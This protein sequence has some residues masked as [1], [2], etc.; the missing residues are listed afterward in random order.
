MSNIRFRHF[1]NADGRMI[2][3]IATQDLPDGNIAVGLSRVHDRDQP[4]RSK[5]RL[6]TSQRL[7]AFA[8]GRMSEHA[9]SRCH[10]FS[11]TRE[12]LVN[13]IHRNPFTDLPNYYTI[14]ELREACR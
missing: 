1:R 13:M 3:T 14:D 11:M 12:E 4:S 8:N 9:K 5:G 7:S 6:I 2:A 10:G